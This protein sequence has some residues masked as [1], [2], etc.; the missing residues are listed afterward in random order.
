MARSATT[1][2]DNGKLM[3]QLSLAMS[4][5][6]QG[7]RSTVIGLNAIKMVRIPWELLLQKEAK[8]NNISEDTVNIPVAITRA[9]EIIS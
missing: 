3:Q 4:S 1:K 8:R 7:I 5:W 2:T 9:E 6:D